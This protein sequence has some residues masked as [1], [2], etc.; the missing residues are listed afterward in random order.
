M[1]NE[2]YRRL[3]NECPEAIRGA[4]TCP[5]GM[6]VPIIGVAGDGCFDT[7]HPAAVRIIAMMGTGERME[8]GHHGE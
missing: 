6:T 7:I 2:L 1:K 5:G 4:V 8:G 3:E